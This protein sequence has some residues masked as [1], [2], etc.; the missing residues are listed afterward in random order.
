MYDLDIP[1][2]Y[3]VLLDNSSKF[4]FH[5][6]KSINGNIIESEKRSRLTKFAKALPNNLL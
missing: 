4:S 2:D 3:I 5:L 6:G 1:Y